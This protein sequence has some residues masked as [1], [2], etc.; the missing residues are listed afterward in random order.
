MPRS[1]EQS[2]ELIPLSHAAAKANVCAATLSRMEARREIRLVR[3]GR[4]V[5]VPLSELRR[6]MNGG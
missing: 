4:R 6:V 3:I 5:M 1:I 2:D